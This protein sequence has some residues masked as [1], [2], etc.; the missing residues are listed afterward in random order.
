MRLMIIAEG[1]ALLSLSNAQAVGRDTPSAVACL[2]AVSVQPL[3]T[4]RVF[5]QA[6]DAD[7]PGDP[8]NDP[9][10]IAYPQRVKCRNE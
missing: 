9:V 4:L 10:D 5:R 1:P 7:V 2:A 3:L 8:P 6:F